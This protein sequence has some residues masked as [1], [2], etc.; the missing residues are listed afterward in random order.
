MPAHE[1]LDAMICKAAQ[2]RERSQDRIV[3]AFR[4]QIDGEG[5][6]PTDEDLQAFAR[7]TA[8]EEALRRSRSAMPPGAA[9]VEWLELVRP[10]PL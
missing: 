10:L 4:Q 7:L 6:G 3:A 5:A 2:M 8:V 1:H 9:V